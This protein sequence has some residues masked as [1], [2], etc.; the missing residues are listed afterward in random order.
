MLNLYHN[1]NI[2][3][4]YF[5]ITVI[6]LSLVS[7]G[8]TSTFS[9]ACVAGPTYKAKS[10]RDPKMYANNKNGGSNLG[11]K[12]NHGVNRGS[13]SF[14]YKKRNPSRHGALRR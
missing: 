12:S 4:P 5:I 13:K 8:E 14:K 6:F 7:C 3:K 2:L 1:Y 10:V 11:S 9:K